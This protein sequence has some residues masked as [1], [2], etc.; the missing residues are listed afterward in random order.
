M[1]R[2]DAVPSEP[3]KRPKT[4][5]RELLLLLRLISNV[6]QFFCDVSEEANGASRQAFGR[7]A[8]AATHSLCLCTTG[9]ACYIPQLGDA[10][11]IQ[12]PTVWSK[13]LGNRPPSPSL[14]PQSNLEAIN[15]INIH[16]MRSICR[17]IMFFHQ[18]QTHPKSRMTNQEN[19]CD[20]VFFRVPHQIRALLLLES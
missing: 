9:L 10:S 1:A 19:G 4:I 17:T 8:E 12:V 3:A 14:L 20:H 2:K 5:S 15:I 16:Q 18:V 11:Q 6:G 7:P 13:P